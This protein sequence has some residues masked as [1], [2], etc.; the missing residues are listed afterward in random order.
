MEISACWHNNFFIRCHLLS[1]FVLAFGSG[2]SFNPPLDI[3][4]PTAEEFAMHERECQ[5]ERD[6]ENGYLIEIEDS[7]G[8]TREVRIN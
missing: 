2:I 6:R 3:H 5:N 7:D 1:I 4:I 8:N